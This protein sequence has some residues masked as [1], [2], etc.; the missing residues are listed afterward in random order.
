MP[1]V[2]LEIHGESR[3][4]LR[5]CTPTVVHGYEL[6]ITNYEL[7]IEKLRFKPN[8]TKTTRFYFRFQRDD[9]AL[10]FSLVWLSIRNS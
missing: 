10:W 1:V 5:L 8:Q 4:R 7:R 9:I 2:G 6:R 3:Q